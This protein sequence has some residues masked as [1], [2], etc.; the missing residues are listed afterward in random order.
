MAVTETRSDRDRRLDK[1]WAEL[2][3]VIGLPDEELRQRVLDECFPD[4]DDLARSLFN[5]TPSL[6]GLGYDFYNKRL[7]FVKGDVAPLAETDAV[8]PETCPVDE[9]RRLLLI[10][11]EA[12]RAD[13]YPKLMFCDLTYEGSNSYVLVMNT[14]MTG[15]NLSAERSLRQSPEW[16]WAQSLPVELRLRDLMTAEEVIDDTAPAAIRDHFSIREFLGV[17]QITVPSEL[18]RLAGERREFLE[19]TR[20][21][22]LFEHCALS[23][24]VLQPEV[25]TRDMELELGQAIDIFNTSVDRIGRRNTSVANGVG[26][27]LDALKSWRQGLVEA[28]KNEEEA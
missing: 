9:L 10:S 24:D 23:L 26:R 8:D 2:D 25:V 22:D 6:C 7:T 5:I 18:C 15:W 4:R 28:G 3:T 17:E 21:A 20:W 13:D 12:L 14:A 27:Q 19:Q 11:F 1:L 16:L